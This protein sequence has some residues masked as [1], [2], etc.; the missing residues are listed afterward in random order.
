M[1]DYDD[2]ER[3]IL[4]PF[5]EESRVQR[6]PYVERFSGCKSVVDL[7]CG[8]GI[9]LEMLVKAGVPAF[10]VDIRRSRFA[11]AALRIVE[12][13]V[14]EFLRR[15]EESFDGLIC[16]HFIEHVDFGAAVELIDLIGKRARDGAVFMLATPNPLSILVHMHTFWT[17]PT[18][19]RMYHPK[20]LAAM[21]ES[22]G[23]D[24]ELALGGTASPEDRSHLSPGD[25]AT[26]PRSRPTE[27]Q[28]GDIRR[29]LLDDF[30]KWTT[31]GRLQSARFDIA[32]LQAEIVDLRGALGSLRQT[33]L[34]LRDALMPNVS[35][36]TIIIGRR[37]AREAS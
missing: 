36:E 35:H 27:A 29:K 4:M 14:M 8:S 25:I 23:F 18:H 3:A 28:P 11:D 37:K 12:S 9:F 17:D 7:A 22:A 33:V 19:I 10:G 16:S 21:V 20:V 30:S 13:D 5:L 6:R 32:E 26:T 34:H 1:F 15:T 24:I 31:A 2:Y